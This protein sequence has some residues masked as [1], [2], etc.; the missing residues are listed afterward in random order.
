MLFLTQLSLLL[1]GLA[2]VS[3]QNS[4]NLTLGPISFAGYNNYVYRDNTTSAQIV[5]TNNASTSAPSRF[6][7]AFPN[8]N[9][10]ALVYFVPGN[11]SSTPLGTTLDFSSVK[12]VNGSFNQTGISGNLS[13][14]SDSQLGVTLSESRIESHS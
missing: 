9:T 7:T 10:G 2:F 13:M 8:G 5:I 1:G 12:S 4:S 6:I 14:S 3:A 11:G